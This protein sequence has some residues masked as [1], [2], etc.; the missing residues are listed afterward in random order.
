MKMSLKILLVGLL[1]IIPLIQNNLNSQYWVQVSVS[2]THS[3]A[4]HQTGSLWLWGAGNEGQLGNGNFGNA[5][6]PVRLDNTR[7]WDFVSCGPG[8]T[9]A[10]KKDGSLWAWGRNSE[11]QLG[12]GSRVNR[13]YPVRIGG[14]SDWA[15]IN[16]SSSHCMALKKDGSLWT[17]G[18]NQRGQLGDGSRTDR[19]APV[20]IGSD[21]WITVSA[22]QYFSTGIQTNHT[23]WSWGDNSKKQ[24][25]FNSATPLF[26]E[27]VKFSSDADWN[28]ITASELHSHSLA[29]K[30]GHYKTLWAWGLNDYGQ[31]GNGNRSD[32]ILPVHTGQSDSWLWVDAGDEY[33]CGITKLHVLKCW[34]KNDFGQLGN[35]TQRD[36]FWPIRIDNTN[37]YAKLAVG[38]NHTCGITVDSVIRCWGDNRNGKLGAGIQDFEVP[39]PVSIQ[40][41][42]V[43]DVD[44]TSE[45]NLALWPNPFRDKLMIHLDGQAKTELNIVDAQGSQQ[46]SLWITDSI[47]EVDLNHLPGGVY[48]LYFK[49]HDGRI[50]I[51]KG[52][53]L[54]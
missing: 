5:F 42:N 27:P 54:H 38:Y 34:G 18:Q 37:Y 31:L 41:P 2:E 15:Y 30:D 12:E 46:M 13:D 49:S 17:W 22:G 53:K 52:I 36:T 7:E 25:G 44:E 50:S 32:V 3:A 20:R 43:S 29:I 33:S 9:H 39:Y 26:T 40:C 16:C 48:I 1:F 24:L 28:M 6:R 4:V 35:G 23:A 51:I 21:T 11:G 8:F 10:I 47:T 19:L 45:K 14:D